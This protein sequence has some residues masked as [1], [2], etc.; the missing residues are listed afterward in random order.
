MG[1]QALVFGNLEF[2]WGQA[3]LQERMAQAE[4][5]ILL[6]NVFNEGTDTRPDWLVPTIMLSVQGQPIGVIGV[7]SK[8][9]PSTVMAGT[10]AGLEFREAGPVVTQL[11]CE[12]RAAGADIVVVLA[13]M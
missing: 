9:T 12:L 8:D 6:A 5:P 11:V 13:H 1:S 2:D 3:R 10:T 7:T 4:F